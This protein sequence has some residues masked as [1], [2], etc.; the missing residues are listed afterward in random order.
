NFSLA[1]N[2]AIGIFVAWVPEGLPATV[3][4]LL[5]IAAKRMATQNVLVKHLQGVET[6]GAITLL[7][8]DKTGTLTRNQM[9]ATNIWT[10]GEMY[11][12]TARAGADKD[13]ASVDKPGVIEILYISAL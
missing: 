8:T 13:V 1:L 11:E 10:C 4:M 7:A 9:T 12:A 2:F 6:L 5:T 3:T